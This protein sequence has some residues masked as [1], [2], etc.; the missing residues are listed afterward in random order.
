MTHRAGIIFSLHAAALCYLLLHNVV[1]RWYD[2]QAFTSA[3]LY[4]W[5]VRQDTFHGLR[6][7]VSVN[8]WLRLSEISNSQ[9]CGSHLTLWCV[10]LHVCVLISCVMDQ[11]EV[12]RSCVKPCWW[13][14]RSPH[15]IIAIAGKMRRAPVRASDLT[16]AYSYLR[17]CQDAFS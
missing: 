13:V 17:R 5:W 9:I 12:W 1:L 8:L 14:G 15:I 10:G 6:L 7:V 4:F 3:G 16:N 11:S 2:S